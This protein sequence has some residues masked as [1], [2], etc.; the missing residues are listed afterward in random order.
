MGWLCQASKLPLLTQRDDFRIEILRSKDT[1]H[2]GCEFLRGE[3]QTLPAFL[4]P[5]CIKRLCPGV[6]LGKGAY[7]EY[8]DWMP[9]Q[10]GE[11]CGV[12]AD[13]SHE[14]LGGRG[15]GRKSGL[16]ECRALLGVIK[17]VWN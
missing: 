17:M 16:D 7:R 13:Y 2:E 4:S 1:E 11:S 12:K 3:G 15:V 5:V 8:S 14:G 10:T 6:M 9:P